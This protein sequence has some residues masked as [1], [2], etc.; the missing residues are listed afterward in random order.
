MYLEWVKPYLKNIKNLT[1]GVKG[2]KSY[3]ILQTSESLISDT[4]KQTRDLLRFCDLN[5]T[6][7]CLEFYKNKRPIKTSSDVQARNKI[8]NTSVRSWKK[9]EKYLEGLF[10]KDWKTPILKKGSKHFVWKK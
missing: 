2:D 1:Q 6:N 10:G 5:W 3:Q 4:E 8:Y 7:A 9:Y